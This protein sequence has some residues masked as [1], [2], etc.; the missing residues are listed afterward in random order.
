MPIVVRA[1]FESIFPRVTAWIFE[2]Q[3]MLAQAE[4]REVRT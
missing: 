4:G 3:A 1:K 2:W